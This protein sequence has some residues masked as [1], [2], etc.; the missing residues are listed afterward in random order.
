MED[1][2]DYSETSLIS[3]VEKYRRTRENRLNLERQAKELEQGEERFLKSQV[4]SIMNEQGFGSVN[5]KT[6]DGGLRVVKRTQKVFFISD[7]ELFARAVMSA[8]VKYAQTGKL[9][10]EGLLTQMRV[11]REAVEQF[12]AETNAELSDLGVSFMETENIAITK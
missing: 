12:A 1:N 4:L 3:L 2:Q 11:S 9:M 5:L 8:M 7:K 10:S 6:E